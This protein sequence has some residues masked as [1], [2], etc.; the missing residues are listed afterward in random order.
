MNK[1]LKNIKKYAPYL[2]FL[3]VGLT[4]G[5]YIFSYNHTPKNNEKTANLPTIWSCSMHPKIKQK[6]AGTCPICAMDLTPMTTDDASEKIEEKGITLTKNALALA[7][8]ETIKITEEKPPNHSEILDGT[9]VLNTALEITQAADFSG[10]VEAV[11]IESEETVVKKGN[12]I[13]TIYAPEVVTAQKELLI[14]LKQKK[15]SSVFKAIRGKFKQWNISDNFVKKLIKT[16]KIIENIPIYA[17]NKGVVTGKIIAGNY[18]KKGDML[19]K[20]N[21]LKNM[22]VDFQGYEKHIGAFEK[23][24]DFQVNMGRK[25][26]KGKIIFVSPIFDEKKRTFTV[27]G[28]IENPEKW[29]KAGMFLRGAISAKNHSKL[30]IYLPKSAVLWTGKRSVVYIKKEGKTHRFEMREVVLGKKIG[31][32]YEILSGVKIGETLVNKGAFTIDAATELDGKKSMI[33]L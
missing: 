12:L 20:T 31:V 18:V 29:L 22:W 1:Y 17:K 15:N 8:I 19:L 32:Y 9:V 28:L 25:I 11:F 24:N 2:L 23:G 27:R 26:A 5:K 14:A 10:R 21:A 6:T 33:N 16:K 7:E 30:G 4:L 13:A 3:T